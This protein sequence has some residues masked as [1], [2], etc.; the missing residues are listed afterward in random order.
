MSPLGFHRDA[1]KLEGILLKITKK[2]TGANVKGV[3]EKAS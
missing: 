1:G 2:A 3:N